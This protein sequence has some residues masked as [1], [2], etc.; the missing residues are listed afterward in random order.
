M[1]AAEDASLNSRI[2]LLTEQL[3]FLPLPS[4][5]QFRFCPCCLSACLT[6]DLYLL[7][8]VINTRQRRT[9]F[10]NRETHFRS[11][12]PF[13][14]AFEVYQ[15]FLECLWPLRPPLWS[16]GQRSLFVSRRWQ[17]FLKVVGLERGPFSLVITIEELLG[18]KNSV[19]GLE[20]REY[21]RRDPWRWPRGALYFAKSWH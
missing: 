12:A 14:R 20:S 11:L 13:P 21:G 19:S 5:P 3:L 6:I 2:S 15:I 8:M 9:R 16:S 4:P 7:C 18:R 10:Q 17:I 1:Y